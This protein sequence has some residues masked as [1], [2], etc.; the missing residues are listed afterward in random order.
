MSQFFSSGGQSIG[1]SASASVFPM[2]I[3]DWFPLGWT[4]WNSSQSKGLS[5][6]FSNTSV[7][8]S[9]LRCSAFFVVRLSHPSVH[10]SYRGSPESDGGRVPAGTTPQSRKCVPHGPPHWAL[11]ISSLPSR[12]PPGLCGSQPPSGFLSKWTWDACEEQ[13]SKPLLEHW[14]Q[15][16]RGKYLFIIYLAPRELQYEGSHWTALPTQTHTSCPCICTQP[17]WTTAQDLQI[18]PKTVHHRSLIM[19]AGDRV[20]QAPSVWSWPLTPS[21]GRSPQGP[22]IWILSMS[23]CTPLALRNC[24]AY[25]WYLYTPYTSGLKGAWPT[26]ISQLIG[27]QTQVSIIAK[28]FTGVDPGG[29]SAVL[30]W[31]KWK[32]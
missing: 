15:R 10:K 30:T 12:P 24:T 19:R 14:K 25:L 7:Q 11:H 18:Q 6:V 26:R 3:Q 22:G 4:A 28:W 2:N 31:D 20:H 1:V 32:S 16:I 23:L 9:I 5:R 13:A 27:T 21:E 17:A 29:N 8:V